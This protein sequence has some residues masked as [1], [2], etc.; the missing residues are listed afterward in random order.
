MKC[1]VCH[2]KSHVIKVSVKEGFVWRLRR[3][4]SCGHKFETK[5]ML[6]DGWDWKS[7]HKNFLKDLKKL[8][9]EYER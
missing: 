8:V 4:N 7:I 6:K 9:D 2:S 3:C 1:P 5:E